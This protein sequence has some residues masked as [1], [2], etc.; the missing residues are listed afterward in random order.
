MPIQPDRKRPS[1][2]NLSHVQFVD[3]DSERD[4]SKKRKKKQSSS[5]DSEDPQVTWYNDTFGYQK[6]QGQSVVVTYNASD[7]G[8]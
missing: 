2:G 7:Y 5:S 6:N 4:K 8:N 3:D 1:Q